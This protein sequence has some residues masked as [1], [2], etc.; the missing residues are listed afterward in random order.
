MKIFNA[1]VVQRMYFN[2]MFYVV[3]FLSLSNL[4]TFQASKSFSLMFD[5]KSGD[6]SC[7]SVFQQKR[8]GNQTNPS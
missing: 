3:F 4:S 7:K 5:T 6:I 8:H 1:Y 2:L